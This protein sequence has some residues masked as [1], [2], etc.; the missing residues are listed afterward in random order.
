M[1]SHQENQVTLFYTLSIKIVFLFRIFLAK[2]TRIDIIGFHSMKETKAKS[3]LFQTLMRISKGNEWLFFFS[4]LAQTLMVI[5]SVFSSFLIKVAIDAL[6][7]LGG[8]NTLYINSMQSVVERFVITI[9]TL[10]KGNDYLL[11]NLS[12]LLPVSIAV[13]ALFL[14]LTSVTRMWL[15]SY[16]TARV[17]ATMQLTLFSHLERLPYPY[18]QSHKPGDM[19]QVCTRDIDVLR[20]FIVGDMSQI[21]YSFWM[22][23]FCFS[24][25]MSL[26]MKLTLVSL[27][28]FPVMFAYSFLLIKEVRKRYRSTDEAE[29]L[30]TDKV[31]ENLNSIRIVKA[32]HNENYEIESF[33]KNLADYHKK[34]V[35]WRKLSAFFFSSTDIFVFASMALSLCYGIYLCYVGDITSS[36]LFLSFTFVN[37][38][39]WPL[40]D[41]AMV[42]SNMGQYLA[43][44]DRVKEVI[45][46]P[47]EDTKTGIRPTIQGNIC[48]KHV[49]FHY[50]NA[51]GVDT[52]RDVSF[53]LKAGQTVAIMGKTGSGKSTLALLLTRIYDYSSGSI[54]IDGHELKTIAREHVRQN[55]V[56][57]LQDPYLFSKSI[58]ENIKIAHQE[59]SK[60][61][62][63]L[64]AKMAAVDNTI[65][66]FKEGYETPV[67]EKGVTLSGGQKQRVAIART[68]LSNAPVI[69]FDDSLS[70]VDTATDIV[71]RQN[72]KN[73]KHKV[74]SFIITHRISTA[75]D[76]DLILVLDEGRVV[77]S[78][79]HQ[80]LIQ[81]EGLYKRIYDIQSKMV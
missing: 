3:N 43:S 18:Y 29:A 49:S 34:Y 2:N 28:L 7:S 56:P 68:L 35:H 6:E 72:L 51:K 1:L 30:I 77:E 24:I 32:F 10:G 78:G 66:S 81:Q 23:V 15:R 46:T 5:V 53:S 64:A 76:A 16:F 80:E 58:G 57:V 26:S 47:I 52:I 71:I 73:L 14:T 44:A 38:M 61:E 75:K 65:L 36:T 37:M 19:L 42:L 22:F 70:A 41:V 20:K 69:I 74:T 27:A 12:W 33:D 45:N 79:T 17:N 13:T 63:R 67:G 62:V 9:I 60:D 25:L 50:E 40:R 48:F 21:N 59:A 31:S 11:D 8:A 55:I 54:L 39:V 4:L